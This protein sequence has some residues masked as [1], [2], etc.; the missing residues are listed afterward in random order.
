MYGGRWIL[1]F[2]L[3]SMAFVWKEGRLVVS[4]NSRFRWWLN[5]ENKNP[6]ISFQV[7][8]ILSGSAEG[9]PK[10]K[11]TCSFGELA[12]IFKEFHFTILLWSPSCHIIPRVFSSSFSLS[13]KSNNS[14]GG[15]ERDFHK[16][17]VYY[18]FKIFSVKTVCLFKVFSFPFC[19]NGERIRSVSHQ[20][21]RCFVCL[22][23]SLFFINYYIS[24]SSSPF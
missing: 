18:T 17:V 22:L 20:K 8:S 6:E 24:F 5:T 7:D 10:D 12:N 23:Q 16:F 2:I 4:H 21:I 1:N 14:V 9:S 15:R 13:R 3:I 19:W 11:Q